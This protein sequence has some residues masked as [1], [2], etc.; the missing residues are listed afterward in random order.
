MRMNNLLK[1][2]VY[3]RKSKAAAK[4]TVNFTTNSHNSFKIKIHKKNKK[5]QN[6]P[7]SPKLQIHLEEKYT[8]FTKKK[9]RKKNI[10]IEKKA[11]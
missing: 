1:A 3:P 10:I 7:Y 8:Q 6:I 4:T 2:K 5:Y 9:K 11:I